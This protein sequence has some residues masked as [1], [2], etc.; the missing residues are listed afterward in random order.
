MATI[1]CGASQIRGR[2]QKE[3]VKNSIHTEKP[4]IVLIGAGLRTDPDLFIL[5]EKIINVVHAQAPGAKIA[6]NKLPY[7][8]L[9][10]IQRW[11]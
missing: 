3:Q 7:D 10:S 6:F 11:G 9:E 1:R 8:S 2:L 5:F 4:D